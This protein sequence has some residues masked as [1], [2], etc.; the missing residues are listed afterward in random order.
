[1]SF[2]KMYLVTEDEFAKLKKRKPARSNLPRDVQMVTNSLKA[3]TQKR[4]REAISVSVPRIKQHKVKAGVVKMKDADVAAPLRRHRRAHTPQ[5]PPP[6]A[7][8]L[9]ARGAQ[10]PPPSPMRLYMYDVGRP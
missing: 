4:K 9:R 6:H 8:Q 5:P 1:M 10:T 3:V 2:A 7:A